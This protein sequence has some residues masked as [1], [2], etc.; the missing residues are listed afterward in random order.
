MSLHPFSKTMFERLRFALGTY[1]QG[2]P[3]PAS[4][5]AAVDR[6]RGSLAFALHRQER[7]MRAID[8][9]QAQLDLA[10]MTAAERLERRIRLQKAEMAELRA[11][12]ARR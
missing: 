1:R 12:R 5:V 8:V 4:A 11:R 10:R 6:Q 3:G 9:K 7:V 2:T